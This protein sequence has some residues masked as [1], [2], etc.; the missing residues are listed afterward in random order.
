MRGL[1]RA[2]LA[3]RILF[4]YRINSVM[5]KG[6]TQPGKVMQTPVWSSI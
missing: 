5:D 1:T 4:D 2:S 3:L 6:F